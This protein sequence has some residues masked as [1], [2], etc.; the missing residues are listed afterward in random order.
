MHDIGQVCVLL[1]SFATRWRLQDNICHD[2]GL[3]GLNGEGIYIVDGQDITIEDSEFYRL[4][5][6]GVNCKGATQGLIVRGNYFHDFMPPS[7]AASQ[8]LLTRL[9]AWLIPPDAQAGMNNSEDTGINCRSAASKKILVE[10]NV[11]ENMPSTGVRMHRVS[12]A[13]TRLNLIINT[14]VAIDYGQGATGKIGGN[15]LYDNTNPYKLSGSSVV[16][17]QDTVNHKVP[18]SFSLPSQCR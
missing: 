12:N 18:D 2:T 14:H 11:I 10:C 5:D 9:L 17:T 7:S 16:P 1:K 15:L 4:K 13:T 8:G 6:E 3:K